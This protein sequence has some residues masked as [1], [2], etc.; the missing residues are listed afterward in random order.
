[1]SEWHEHPAPAKVNLALVVGPVRPDGRHEV[2]TVLERVSLADTVAVRRASST[3]VS[4][5]EHDT[6]VHAALQAMS[7][8][9]GGPV[10]FEARIDK[11]IPVAAGLG[12]GSSDAATA[13]HLANRLLDEPLPAPTLHRVAASLG[14][15]VPFFLGKGSQLATGDGTSLQPIALP[16]DYTVLLALEHGAVKASTAEVYA[17][18]DRRRGERGFDERR[19]ALVEAADATTNLADLVLLPPNDLASSPLAD[20]IRTLGAFRA[21]V[22]G[23]GPVVY[24]LFESHQEALAAAG[25]LGARAATWVA[26]PG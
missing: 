9:A 4:G 16:R 3:R 22:T 5:F 11:R 17:A 2:V 15:D 20:E 7:A 24:G 19:A 18:F 6:I 23:A 26:N 10:C 14:A 1:V 13:L 21:D 8:A 25:A 12:G